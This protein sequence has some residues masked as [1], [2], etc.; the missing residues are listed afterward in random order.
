MQSAEAFLFKPSAA[1]RVRRSTNPDTP[2][3]P[4]EPTAQNPPD[5]AVL[6]YFLAQPASGPVTLE[7]LDAQ[8]K[9]V[10]RY[11][12]TD[13]PGASE[14]ELAK[15]L[16]PTNWIRRT[17]V[18]STAAGMHRWIWDLHYTTPNSPRFD[19]P[20][21]AVPGDTPLT[22]QGPLALPAQY[23]VK[24]TVDGHT[25]SELLTVKMDPRVKTPAA[26]LAQMFKME[27][28][29]AAM[30]SENSH[31]LAEA[32]SAREQLQKLS[33]QA[34][35]PLADAISALD[36]KISA[37]LGGGG[38][39]PRGAASPVPTISSM[40][41]EIGALYGEVERADATP[42]LAQTNALADTEKGLSGVMK[43]WAAL[44]GADLPALNQQL[45]T[46]N[47][48]EIHLESAAPEQGASEDI[49]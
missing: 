30:M 21:S 6:D 41:G 7:I 32:R 13:K 10:R 23:T 15:Q 37:V 48:Q 34:T 43:Q 5:G 49:E 2:I 4:D 26:G 44:K 33:K 19:Y 8:G 42:T 31:A 16:I 46:A 29:L 27:S 3:P 9:L 17:G 24:L 20:I 35:G 12:S 22:P 18:L 45:R 1:Y 40:S 38:G 25:N 47:L 14:E 11:A 39:G 36:K 28:R